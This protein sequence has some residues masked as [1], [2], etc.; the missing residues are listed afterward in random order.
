MNDDPEVRCYALWVEHLRNRSASGARLA[1]DVRRLW[2][3]Q[4][5]ADDGC[6]GAARQLY[7][8]RQLSALDI[9]RKVRLAVEAN[10]SRVARDAIDIV[11]PDAAGLLAQVQ[12]EPARFLRDKSVAISRQR[13]ELVTL[14]L[15]RLAGE[16]A[17]AA[18]EQIDKKWGA[19]LSAEE[20]NWVWGSIGRRSAMRLERE[21]LEHFSRVSRLGD[22]SDDMLAWKARAALRAGSQPN[23][24]QVLAAIGAMSEP[25]AR[26]PPPP[27]APR[28]PARTRPPPKPPACMPGR[29]RLRP[30]RPQ[31][32][33]RRSGRRPWC[34]CSR[35]P[36]CAAFM[37]SS[38]SKS[39]ASASQCPP[40]RPP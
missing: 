15:L 21:A 11:A 28:W 8:D 5:D 13:K 34:C 22:L 23:W 39:W 17:A 31:R 29:C 40:N 33:W 16:D 20:R 30:D 6:K 35:L 25:A 24:P 26:P 38:P 12:N 3:A 2:H 36:R 14:A 37:N 7:E 18:I 32:P 27:P 10:R 19:Q 4:R 1:E 9:W